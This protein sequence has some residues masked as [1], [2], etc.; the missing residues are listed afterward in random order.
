MMST[1]HAA[2]GLAA[3]SLLVPVSPELAS[4]AA[5]GAIAGGVFP[6]LDIVFAHRK[7]LHHPEAYP[8]IA[9]LAMAIAL[10]SP[11]PLTVAVAAFLGSA[12]L[13][14]LTDVL[15][16][17]LGLR[18][19]NG[20]DERGIY[21]HRSGR[22]LPPRR[23]VRYDGAPED[24]LV[25][26]AFSI[27]PYLLFDGAFTEVILVGLGISAAYVLLRKRLVDVYEAVARNHQGTP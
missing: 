19:W 3:A 10:F 9:L 25:T 6:D 24:F 12:A 23:W 16:G 1:T 18:P 14:C 7:T 17:G 4:V 15:G 20:D 27:P 26:L 11:G 2:M 8:P 5:V 21:L 13:H 22:W